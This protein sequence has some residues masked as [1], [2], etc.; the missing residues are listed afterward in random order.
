MTAEGF[1]LG[2]ERWLDLDTGNT[3]DLAAGEEAAL[4]LQSRQARLRKSHKSI[5]SPFLPA[6]ELA[7]FY[8]RRSRSL[9]Y[10]EDVDSGCLCLRVKE[11]EDE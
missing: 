9:I 1:K 6:K 4:R 10:V 11:F 8:Q 7:L 2:R 5:Y 3:G